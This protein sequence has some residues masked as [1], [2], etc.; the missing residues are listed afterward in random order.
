MTW[1]LWTIAHGADSK[2]IRGRRQSGI[3]TRPSGF[4]HL[5]RG[6]I[7]AVRGRRPGMAPFF[8]T[9]ALPC[10]HGCT[11]SETN[12]SPNSTASLE[13]S[14]P[15]SAKSDNDERPQQL[16]CWRSKQQMRLLAGVAGNW[17]LR[18]ARDL[19]SALQGRLPGIEA[20]AACIGSGTNGHNAGRQ[21]ASKTMHRRTVDVASPS[22]QKNSLESW[23]RRPVKGCSVGKKDGFTR[24]ASN[25]PAGPQGG[26]SVPIFFL[27]GNRDNNG[28]ERDPHI[29][30]QRSAARQRVRAQ[31]EI[32]QGALKMRRPLRRSV[33]DKNW[34]FTVDHG[35][36][37]RAE[38]SRDE[39]NCCLPSLS[40]LDEADAGCC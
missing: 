12:I 26:C 27:P 40:P 14:L 20:V 2:R 28:V 36:A 35:T 29:P 7:K 16:N 17:K 24:F 32:R 23:K 5:D 3:S 8:R 38:Q 31:R 22:K 1:E 10:R 25:M 18:M 39:T 6:W 37:N 30:T 9:A 13:V 11:N 33:L 19:H 4:M 15:A 34:I 21:F